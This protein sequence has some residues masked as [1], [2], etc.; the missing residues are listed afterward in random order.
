MSPYDHIIDIVFYHFRD[1]SLLEV[2]TLE[3]NISCHLPGSAS[4][5]LDGFN[6][7]V[8][9]CSLRSVAEHGIQKIKN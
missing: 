4:G 7:A 9:V 8:C 5:L 2:P 3:S 6:V 1:L